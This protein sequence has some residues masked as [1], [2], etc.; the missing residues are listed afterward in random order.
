MIVLWGLIF[1]AV[2]ILV[3]ALLFRDLSIKT[4]RTCVDVLF[5][6]LVLWLIGFRLC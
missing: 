3:D 5:T 6:C 2:T 1:C 4:V